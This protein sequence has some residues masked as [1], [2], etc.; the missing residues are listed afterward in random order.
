MPNNKSVMKRVRTN[1]KK[2]MNNK[3][4]KTILKNTLQNFEALLESGKTEEI[5]ASYSNIVKKIDQAAAD[6]ILHKN[7]AARLVSRLTKKYNEVVQ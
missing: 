7:K 5:K 2:N 6:N 3:S 4:A 1:S